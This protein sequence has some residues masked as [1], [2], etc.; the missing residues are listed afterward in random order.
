MLKHMTRD[1]DLGTRGH[2]ALPRPIQRRSGRRLLAI[3]PC[4]D[5]ARNSLE[6]AQLGLGRIVDQAGS[7]QR[8]Q[9]DLVIL[10]VFAQE[11][12]DG[13]DLRGP[14]TSSTLSKPN[15]R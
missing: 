9:E 4:I 14:S 2:E 12:L 15:S 13:P 3:D 8:N 10:L 6:L 7:T 11:L 1:P 5:L